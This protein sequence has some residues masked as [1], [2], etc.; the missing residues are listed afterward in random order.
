[1]LIERAVAQA[2]AELGRNRGI[3]ENKENA[4]VVQGHTI[5]QF[6]NYFGE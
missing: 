5:E 4:V 3:R 1:M 2:A 6:R